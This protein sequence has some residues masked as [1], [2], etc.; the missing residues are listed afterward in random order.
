MLKTAF[1]PKAVHLEVI[2]SGWS[3]P[4]TRLEA[5]R[6][7]F[8]RRPESSKV[9]SEERGTEKVLTFHENYFPSGAGKYVKSGLDVKCKRIARK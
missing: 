7:V 2:P 3:T 9:H 4:G 5:T 6:R 1:Y 8:V